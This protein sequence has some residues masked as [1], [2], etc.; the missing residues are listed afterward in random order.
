MT[1]T[2]RRLVRRD[3]AVKALAEAVA[4]LWQSFS[5]VQKRRFAA[6]A[7][8]F[9]IFGRAGSGSEAQPAKTIMVAGRGV[10]VRRAVAAT[11]TAT[12]TGSGRSG[13]LA[14]GVS[15]AAA[16][17]TITATAS[18]GASGARAPDATT[19]DLAYGCR[20]AKGQKFGLQS[21]P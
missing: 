11:V 9:N 20:R 13:G 7:R 1:S 16:A 8:P 10:L 19:I 6:L 5:G 14:S 3:A 18:A 12:A 4:P 17:T 15:M 2:S 21:N